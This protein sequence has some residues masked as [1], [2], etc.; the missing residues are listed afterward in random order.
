MKSLTNLRSLARYFALGD[1]TSTDFSDDDTLLMANARYQESFIVAANE[2]TDWQ[3][4]G[5]GKQTE[6]IVAAT[7]QYTLATDLY[8]PNRVEIKYPSS[9]SYLPAKPI[10]YK[11]VEKDG[12]DNY[13]ASS[14]EFDLKGTKIDIFVSDKTSSI[15]A[16]A[17]GILIYYQTSLTELTIAGSEIIFPDAFAR[18]IALGMAIDYCG[19]NSMNSRLNWLTGEHQKAEAK[20]IDYLNNRNDTKRL[21]LSF[22]TE[23][24]GSQNLA[25][26]HSNIKFE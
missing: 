22:K 23:D 17:S 18:Y 1:S 13:T 25:N 2:I 12:L 24:Y 9:G 11:L 14:P 3:I 4:S 10:D 26:G 19:V 21:N 8:I 20:F 5:T 16:V 7:R 15:K 6:S